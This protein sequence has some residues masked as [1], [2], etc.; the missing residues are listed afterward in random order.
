MCFIIVSKHALTLFVTP[1]IATTFSAA[2]L[3]QPGSGSAMLEPAEA[4]AMANNM[5]IV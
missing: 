2:A 4:W 1:Q 5:P 3:T